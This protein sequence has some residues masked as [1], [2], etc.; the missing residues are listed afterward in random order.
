MGKISDIQKEKEIIGLFLLNRESIDCAIEMN[1]NSNEIV[2]DFNKKVINIILEKCI[3]DS[4]FIPTINYI[5]NKLDIEEKKKKDVHLKLNRYKKMIQREIVD[6]TQ[7]KY[8]IEDNINQLRDLNIKRKAIHVIKNGLDK[9]EIPARQFISNITKDLMNIE[10]NDGQVKEISI[11]SG[12]QNIKEEM[13]EQLISDKE[14]SYYFKFRDLDIMI[15]DQIAKDTL[16]YIVGRPSNYKTGLALNCAYNSAESGIPNA[17]FSH[18]MK[19][20]A[21]YRRILSRVAKI[22]MSKLKNPKTLTQEE[23]VRLDEAIEHVK[24]IPLYV[25]DA[26]KVNIGEAYTTLAYLKSKYGIEIVWFDYFQLI[27]K[28]NGT[29]PTDE[30]DFAE[31]SEDLRNMASEFDVAV[32]ALSQANRNCEKRDDKRPTLADIRNTGKAEQD[33]HNIFY[34]YRDEF[35]F[36]SKSEVPN[37]LEIG[38]LKVREGELRK[39]LLHFNGSKATLNN[40]DPMVLI[41]KSLEYIGGGGRID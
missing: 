19:A 32:I 12:F 16:T 37:H 13:Q 17:I 2:N 22:D 10:I 23:W 26:A 21:V 18:E 9:I 35:Y 40:A 36:R 38:A 5:I 6:D 15:K 1:F 27:R 3:A 14:F 24:S 20:P 11:Y 41:D 34:V 28:R 29:I 25:I 8:I 31:I 30:Q 39:V 7:Y 33:A 4:E